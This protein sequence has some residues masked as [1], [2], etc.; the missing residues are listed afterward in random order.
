MPR[1]RERTDEAMEMKEIL[2]TMKILYVEDEAEARE[3]L[4]DVLKR[5]AGKVITAENGRRGL[6]MFEIHTP[7]II[8][9]DLYMPE[10]DGLEML[11]RIR[12]A[13]HTPAVI[14]VSAVEDVGTILDAIDTGIVKYILKPVNMQELLEVLADRAAEIYGRRQREL[15][16]LPEN[17]KRAEDEMK[18]EFASMLKA[19]TGKGPRDV[20]VFMA[21]D[22]IELVAS[23]VLTIFEKNLLDNYQNIAIIR[24]IREL[25]FSVK[26]EAFCE[27]L[28]RISGRNVSYKE[29][30]VNVE[31]DRNKLIFTIQQG[32]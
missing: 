27:M 5:R 28:S 10:M 4:A 7:D 24:Y 23:E 26:A 17:R 3:E 16:A 29:V 6:E 9:A 1:Q 19:M 30:Q 12:E 31:K 32:G 13:G 22:R 14:V 11:R 25:F 2:K 15:A 20:S 21:D 8:I 18:K